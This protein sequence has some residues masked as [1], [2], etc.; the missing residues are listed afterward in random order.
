MNGS[1]HTKY[2]Y[3]WRHSGMMRS[4]GENAS[5]GLLGPSQSRADRAPVE[6]LFAAVSE[7]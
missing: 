7:N 4:Y 1:S 2:Y 3:K 5:D 6:G